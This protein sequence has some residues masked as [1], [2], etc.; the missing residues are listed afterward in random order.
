MDYAYL[1]V[2]SDLLSGREVRTSFSGLDLSFLIAELV[3]VLVT[4]VLRHLLNVLTE[5]IWSRLTSIVK[6]LMFLV[7]VNLLL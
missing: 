7:N 5:E 2:A 4:R 1:V 3:V 6:N